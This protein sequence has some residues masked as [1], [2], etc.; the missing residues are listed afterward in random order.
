MSTTWTTFEDSNTDDS[1][2]NLHTKHADEPAF[3]NMTY[4]GSETGDTIKSDKYTN[5]VKDSGYMRTGSDHHN[6]KD[7]DNKDRW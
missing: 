5:N 2:L 7:G 1:L 4:I 6:I 3:G